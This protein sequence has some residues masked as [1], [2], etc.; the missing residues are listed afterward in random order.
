MGRKGPG[1][2]QAAWLALALMAMAGCMDNGEKTSEASLSFDDGGDGAHADKTD[3]TKG[4][5]LYGGGTVDDGQ[6]QVTVT[7]GE[8][9]EV[10]TGSYNDALD[11]EA[12]NLEGA[13]GE[14]TLT[15]QR[16]DGFAGDYLFT[17]LCT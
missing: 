8:G 6:V 15:A 5:S 11:L 17:L 3:C 14:W 13:D 12:E 16:E 1:M 2:K 7:D 9:N 10:F 4:A